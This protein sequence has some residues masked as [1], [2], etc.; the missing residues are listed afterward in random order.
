MFNTNFL[1]TLPFSDLTVQIAL[2]A[3]TELT[4]TVP[5]TTADLY[6]CE[7]SWAYNASVWVGYNTTASV[8]PA[9]AIT[10]SSNESLEFRPGIRYVRGGDVLHFI[11]DS[12]VTNGGFSLL[13]LPSPSQ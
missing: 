10:T 12:I 1:G 3:T 9:G 11:S 5:G 13:K 6:R 8:P 7:F 4:Y 2:A